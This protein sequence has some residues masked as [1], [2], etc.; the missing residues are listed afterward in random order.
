MLKEGRARNVAIA[1]AASLGVGAA[2]TDGR[3]PCPEYPLRSGAP[4]APDETYR[5]VREAFR[6]LCLDEEHLGTPGWNPL[7]ELIRPGDRVL[8]K[9]NLI[10]AAHPERPAEWEQLIT[11][12]SLIRAVVAFVFIALEGRGR[13][14]IADG[15]QTDSDFEEICRRTHLDDIAAQFRALGLDVVVLDLRRE[16]WLQKD[17]VT[18]QRRALAGDPSGYTEI[19]LGSKSE[20]EHGYRLTGRFYG[21]DY[22]TAETARYHSG[23][24]HRYVLCRTAMDADVVINL[25]KMKTHKKTGVTLSLKNMVGINGY[26]NCLPHHTLG[27]PSDGGDEFAVSN[28][29][30]RLQGRLLSTVKKLITFRGSKGGVLARSAFKLGRRVFGGTEEVVRSGNWW[31]NDTTWR[32][33][34]DLNKCLFRFTGDGKERTKPLRYL[35]IVDGMTAGEGNGPVHVD[36]KPCGLI[37]CGFNPLAVDAVCAEIMGFDSAC[38]PMLARGFDVQEYPL[39]DFAAEAIECSSNHPQWSGSFAQLRRAPHMGFRP[40][41]GWVGRIE[42]PPADR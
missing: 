27:T 41:F 11:H 5:T 36:A 40:H 13:V 31:G 18:Y 7:G 30:T 15:P 24:Q 19:D 25:P 42:R 23:G 22:D 34:L 3:P 2:A 20:F 32:M 16:C 21:A 35:S 12:P 38:I 37:V 28:R 14:T 6:L 9:P 4:E 29:R 10:R 33:V 26:R 8:I 1:H 17:G 39:A